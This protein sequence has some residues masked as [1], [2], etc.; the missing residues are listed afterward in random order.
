MI[1]KAATVALALIAAAA[2]VLALGEA[3]TLI[4]Q[5]VWTGS[6]VAVLLLSAL[7]LRALGAFD[8]PIKTK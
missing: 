8:E 3:D 5:I 4:Q 7:G 2:F 1:K 6:W